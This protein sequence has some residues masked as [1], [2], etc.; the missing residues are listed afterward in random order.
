MK[1][2]FKKIIVTDIDGTQETID[3]SKE[4]GQLLYRTAIRQEGL[5]IAK[6]LYNEGELEV[7]AFTAKAL[8]Q[9]IST[10]FLAIIQNAIIPTLE[11]IIS[12]EE[13][14]ENVESSVE[15][16]NTDDKLSE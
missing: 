16:V 1:I 7:D 3:I 8:K 10:N 11:D 13:K 15:E 6:T 12:S 2:D 4:I 5:D 9:L 14:V